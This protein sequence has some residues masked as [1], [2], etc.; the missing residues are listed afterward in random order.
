MP[1]PPP[2]LR[3]EN[4]DACAL[5][6]L[7]MVLASQNVETTEAE[8]AEASAMQPGGLDPEEIARLAEHYGLRATEQQLP[9]DKLFELIEAERFP[10]AVVY[11]RPIDAVESGHA[12]VPVGLS[13]RY[14][15][16][17]DPLYGERRATVKK[18]EEARR[19]AGQWVVVWEP[20]A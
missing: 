9:T 13:R 10:I 12:V 18:F 8:L 20:G 19:L 5:A 16:F 2:F 7:R 14:V 6:C 17:L 11:R 4:P 3:Q 15:T 1:S